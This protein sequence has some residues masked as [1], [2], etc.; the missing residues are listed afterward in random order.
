[1]GRVEACIFDLDGVI[2]S[3]SD[4]HFQ[5]WGDLARK[6]GFEFTREDNERLKGVSRMESLD[7]LLEVGGLTG[8]HSKEEKAE[9]ATLK[10]TAYLELVD[11]LT[12]KDVFPGVKDLVRS[13]KE[14]GIKVAVG[15]A[16]KNAIRILEKLEMLG[17]FDAVVDGH[18]VSNAKPSPEVFL[19][20]AKKLGAEP[21]N[22]VVI[23]D[24]VAGVQAAINA[25]MR[26]IGI[27]DKNI[28]AAADFCYEKM[29]SLTFRSFPYN[30]QRVF[31]TAPT[32]KDAWS[33]E[34]TTFCPETNEIAESLFSIGN[35]YMG[36]R[37]NFE[38][39]YTG[40]T[41]KGSY[42]AGIYYPDKTKVGWWK[43]GYPEYFAKVL[44]S[45]DWI[46]IV[47]KV[48]GE[49]VDLAKC[50]VIEFNRKLDMKA[51]L[52]MRKARVK[53]QNKKEIEI[54]SVRFVSM[55]RKEVGAISYTVKS[56]SEDVDIELSLGLDGNVQNSDAN[57]GNRFW[58]EEEK[59]WTGD[60]A[61]TAFIHLKTEKT[62]FHVLSTMK[63]RVSFG[64]E[65][66]ELESSKDSRDLYVGQ[67]FKGRLKAGQA[68]QV[69]KYTAHTT[70]RDHDVKQLKEQSRQI[71]EDA[72]EQGFEKLREEHYASWEKKWQTSD[73]VIEGDVSSQQAVRFNIFHLQQ[74]YT[75]EDSRLNIGPKGFTGEKYGGS[76]YWDTEAFCFPFYMCT[77]D[78]KIAKNLLRYRLNHLEK[79]KENARK[80]G[81]EKGALYPMVTMNG[82]ECHNEWEITFEEIHRNGAIAY[83]IYNYTRYVG[84]ESYLLEGGLKVLVELTRFWLERSVFHQDRSTYMILGVTGPNE[85]ENNVN[86]N[87]YTNK[88]A[89][90]TA[91]YTVECMQKIRES[92][93]KFFEA[94]V[95]ELGI[96]SGEVKKWQEFYE[97]M[98]FPTDEKTG[99]YLQQDGF[100]DK[101]IIP[102]NQLTANDLPLCQKWSWDRILRSCFI[103]QADTLQG[104]YFLEE[105]YS[106]EVLKKHFDFY[107]PLTVH[108]SSLSPS[109]HAVLACR[110]GRVD[111]AY[112]LFQRTA[113]LDLDNYN[114][115]TEDGCHITS[116]VGS[117]LAVVEGFGGVKAEGES[118]T[119][120]PRIPERWSKFRFQLIFRGAE[121]DVLVAKDRVLIKNKSGRKVAINIYDKNYMMQEF[122]EVQENIRN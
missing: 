119:F 88:V 98:Y 74:T 72:F 5:A 20:A 21:Q 17:D 116:M 47:M 10:N 82:E 37:A 16:S 97:K 58:I 52:L 41:L 96:E 32:T 63:A 106:E 56:M 1:M 64:S 104:M 66:V 13:L 93:P 67:K 75:G 23:E 70:S 71:L 9:L 42:F 107:E 26:S 79:A 91:K 105:E 109:I 121:L 120:R 4:F 51:G 76:T 101:E 78:P 28:L 99:L 90:W 27:G 3:T 100:L 15:S 22:C 87:W 36:Q 102:V 19:E 53:T 43:N 44:N 39:N 85:Y 25:G 81:I 114:N 38:E 62:G 68:V 73:V 35:G 77:G 65:G 57:Y 113:R 112:E 110:L 50:E 30:I 14:H 117:W 111:K 12:P 108:E 55:A 49:L 48:D 84:D 86:N 33:V 11:T 115:D 2:V 69:L 103:K 31:N 8:K 24:A 34:Q 118:L 60:D 59:G 92:E 122:S 83:A 45:V 46:N 89:S 40:K 7:I 80:L 6:L 54:E 95:E 29:E 18:M 61:A 94:F